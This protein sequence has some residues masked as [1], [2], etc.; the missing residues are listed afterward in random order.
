[1]RLWTAKLLFTLDQAS[2]GS[3]VMEEKILLLRAAIDVQAWEKAGSFGVAEEE[4]FTRN[5]VQIRWKFEGILELKPLPDEGLVE[6]DSREPAA[7]QFE[8]TLLYARHRIENTRL[9]IN[10]RHISEVLN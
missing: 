5:G 4:E 8:N 6:I 2:A 1:M 9:E 3:P 7:T 10:C